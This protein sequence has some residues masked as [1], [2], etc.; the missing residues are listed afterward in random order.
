MAF[1]D[2]TNNAVKPIQIQ[3]NKIIRICLNKHCIEGFTQQNYIEL[4]VPI[5]R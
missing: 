3:Q 5:A 1:G 2:Y 4:G